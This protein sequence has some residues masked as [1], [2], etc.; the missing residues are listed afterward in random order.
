MFASK[1]LMLMK[2]WIYLKHGMNVY[3]IKPLLFY[4]IML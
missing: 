2:C 1:F 4:T 3:L